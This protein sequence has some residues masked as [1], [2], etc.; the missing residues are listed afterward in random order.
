M[1]LPTVP[2]A[3]VWVDLTRSCSLEE[4]AWVHGDAKLLT[5][6]QAS[7]ES[8]QVCSP[9]LAVLPPSSRAFT[10]IPVL[11]GGEWTCQ[12]IT[13]LRQPGGL[14]QHCHVGPE[15]WPGA[16]AWEGS[17]TNVRV[18]IIFD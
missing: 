1:S 16:R 2:W 18:F 5:E 15:Q 17:V 7:A 3:S 11:L 4:R 13:C 12:D 8:Q 10:G 9:W 6:C 14:S